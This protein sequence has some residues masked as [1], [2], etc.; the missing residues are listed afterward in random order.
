MLNATIES[1]TSATNAPSAL[2]R[3]RANRAT[4]DV[5]GGRGSTYPFIGYS[6]PGISR[7][8]RVKPCSFDR[9][10][11]S[12]GDGCLHCVPHGPSGAKVR[13]AFVVQVDN[14]TPIVVNCEKSVTLG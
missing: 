14:A 6:S 4:K 13:P 3:V 2:R 11:G 8:A 12:G 10:A 5:L 1:A 9:G 7:L